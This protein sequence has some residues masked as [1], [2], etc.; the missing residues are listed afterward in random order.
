MDISQYAFASLLWILTL[1]FKEKE[2]ILFQKSDLCELILLILLSPFTGG[3]P[4][5]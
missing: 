1:Q 3:K 2:H 4:N 5:A